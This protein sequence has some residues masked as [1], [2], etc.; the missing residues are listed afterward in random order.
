MLLVP[1]ALRPKVTYPRLSPHI[2]ILS[3]I[4]Q[5]SL[6]DTTELAAM[7]PLAATAGMPAC[8]AAARWTDAVGQTISETDGTD[9][10]ARQP[11][12]ESRGSRGIRKA[13][14]ALLTSPLSGFEVGA[15]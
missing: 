1:D 7:W 3:S 13:L 6:T 4:F 10:A 12:W 11:Q 15:P 2:R 8:S 5:C 14:A 9:A